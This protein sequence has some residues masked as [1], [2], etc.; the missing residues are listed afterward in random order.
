MLKKKKIEIILT[1]LL[2]TITLFVFS[3]NFYNEILVKYINN[4]EFFKVFFSDFIALHKGTQFLINDINPYQE[5]LNSENY[6]LFIN[7]LLLYIFKYLGHFSYITVAKFWLFFSFIS[8]ILIPLIAKKIYNLNYKSILIFFVSFGGINLS[9]FLTGNISIL[10]GLIF[11]LAL[12]FLS[13]N[14]EFFYFLII[15]LL[16]LIKFPYLIFFGLPL[17]LKKI[18]LELFIKIFIYFFLIFTCYLIFFYLDK[19]LFLS[20]IESLKFSKLIGDNGDFGRGLF[21]IINNIF[22]LKYSLNI[23]ICVAI[24]CMLFLFYYYIFHKSKILK[25]KNLAIALGVIALTACLPRLKSYNL[26]VVIPSMCFLIQSLNFRIS[27]IVNI[28]LKFTL[29]FILI[30]WTSPYAPLS[31]IFIFVFLFFIDLKLNFFQWKKNL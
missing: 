30:C 17:L 9:V 23:F 19:E 6:P 8:F 14:N 11:I 12:Y 31:L 22:P 2:V 29:F 16:S 18:N 3:K 7:P 26:L 5:S 21:R 25:N 20:W 10:L 27:N 15:A 1:F 13:K 4:P 24:S 28:Y